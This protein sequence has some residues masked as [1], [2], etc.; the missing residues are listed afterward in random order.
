[1]RELDWNFGRA[2]D[3][4]EHIIRLLCHVSKIIIFR[5]PHDKLGMNAEEVALAAIMEAG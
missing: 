4:A 3:I 2:S 5:R 1:L